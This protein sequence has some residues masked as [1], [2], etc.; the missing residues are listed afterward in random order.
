MFA[1]KAAFCSL[2]VLWAG[3]LLQDEALDKEIKSLQGTWK[4]IDSRVNGKKIPLEAYK[5]VRIAIEKTQITFKDGGKPFDEM[6]F[7][8][9]PAAKPP[10]IDYAYV[11]GLKK[12][13]YE[14]SGEQLKICVAPSRGPRPTEFGSPPDSGVQYLVLQR[15]SSP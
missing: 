10:A 7:T 1:Y 9:N 4:V 6:Q 2:S 14:L 12:G 11:G 5:N 13:I 3:T 8:L 15:Q